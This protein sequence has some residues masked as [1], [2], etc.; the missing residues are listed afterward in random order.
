MDHR[1]FVGGELYV[2]VMSKEMMGQNLA[3]HII[4]TKHTISKNTQKTALKIYPD[5]QLMYFQYSWMNE[6]IFTPLRVQKL[7]PWM[8]QYVLWY[9]SMGTTYSTQQYFALLTFFSLLP[10]AQKGTVTLLHADHFLY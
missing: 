7:K 10:G 6:E 9:C 8:L 3:K 1:L 5:F 2:R 4:S